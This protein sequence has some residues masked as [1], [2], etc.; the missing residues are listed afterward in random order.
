MAQRL[1]LAAIHQRRAKI[2]HRFL[3][4]LRMGEGQLQVRTRLPQQGTGEG[5]V[6][7]AATV[8]PATAVI[9]THVQ[10][11]G[12][13]G[14]QRATTAEAQPRGVLAAHGHAD[15][16]LDGA[17]RGLLR[18]DVDHAADRTVAM[19][20]RGRSTQHFNAVDRPGIERKGDADAPV[21][22]QPVIQSHHRGPVGEA[23]A[24]QRTQAIAGVRHGTDRACPA[25]RIVEVRVTALLQLFARDDGQAGRCL[26][27]AQAQRGT[28]AGGGRKFA[29]AGVDHAHG[30]QRRRWCRVGG[31][32]GRGMQEQ[33]AQ[34]RQ[35]RPAQA[36]GVGGRFH[37]FTA[38]KATPRWQGSNQKVTNTRVRAP[39]MAGNLMDGRSMQRACGSGGHEGR[40]SARSQC[41]ADPLRQRPHCTAQ[42]AADRFHRRQ[43]QQCGHQQ[44]DQPRG[45]Q[46][47]IAVHAHPMVGVWVGSRLRRWFSV[48][49]RHR[50]MA[51]VALHRVLRMLCVR[52]VAHGCH[53]CGSDHVALCHSGS[54]TGRAAPAAWQAMPGPGTGGG[55]QND[56]RHHSTGRWPTLDHVQGFQKGAATL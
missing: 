29:A 9:T 16:V 20:H 15:L 24:G 6:T 43:Q 54:P 38:C 35:R 55:G 39:A 1:Q 3:V 51:A 10:P 32:Q 37:F 31:K 53:R 52:R 42:R 17:A 27:H 22:A 36:R 5:G 56:A 28:G 45:D 4:A 50:V 2:A 30:I 12:Q 14:R 41:A 7:V 19:D 25:D 21:L 34:D 49:H 46:A 48:P 18:H 44:G 13:L 40:R 23:A 11:V 47:V 33:R 8:N 26:Q